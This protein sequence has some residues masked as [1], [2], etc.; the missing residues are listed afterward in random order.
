MMVGQNAAAQPDLVGFY[1]TDNQIDMAYGADPARDRTQ[2]PNFS[3]TNKGAEVAADFIDG[4]EPTDC[5]DRAV[6]RL[7]SVTDHVRA[8]YV[9]CYGPF[10]SLNHEKQ[11]EPGY[12]R[13][14]SIE[15]TRLL[16][17]VHLYN[18]FKAAFDKHF[19]KAPE[20]LRV[21]TD[22]VCAVLGEAYR[23]YTNNGIW[24]DDGR[25]RVLAF[26]KVSIGIGGAISR[27]TKPY[28]GQLHTEMG[29]IIVRKWR[30]PWLDPHD[31]EGRFEG[32]GPYPGRLES[33]ASVRAIEERFGGTPFEEL[34]KF[35][36][37]PAWYRQAWYLA[38]AVMAL[39]ALTAPSN[40]IL[41]GRV[42]G[43]PGLLEKVQREFRQFLGVEPYPRYPELMREDYISRDAFWR[44]GATGRPG[45]NGALVLAAV[46]SRRWVPDIIGNR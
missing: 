39:T 9:G 24:I 12:G 35:P 22:V 11:A 8:A 16:R 34:A 5:I 6:E 44:P 20:L 40:V 42:M 43:V 45:A 32:I 26:L 37:H 7:R 30:N 18:A 36:E 41:G 38:Q 46:R 31:Y 14:Q 4:E 17:G 3:L 10:V 25:S 29:Q 21:E 23:R 27:G 2:D 13:L 28:N 19:E 33:L 15:P 1:I